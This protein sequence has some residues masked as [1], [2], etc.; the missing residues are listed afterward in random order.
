MTASSSSSSS[1]ETTQHDELP[2]NLMSTTVD[3]TPF[4][5][6]MNQAVK[7]KTAQMA[8]LRAEYDEYPTFYRN[9]IFPKD[10]AI[11]GARTASSFR[12]RLEEARRLKKLGNEEYGRG[13][14]GASYAKYE[15]AV[16][17]F[18]YLENKNPSWKTEGIK[19]SFIKKVFYTGRGDKEK[20]QVVNFL[21]ICYCNIANVCIKTKDYQTSI[22]ACGEA[23]SLD[24]KNAKAL[25]LRSRARTQP[26]SAGATEHG[27]AV[28]DLKLAMEYSP[29]DAT[30]RKELKHLR[31]T[32]RSGR[33]SDK[34]A[35]GGV[36]RKNNKK[37]EEEHSSD[38]ENIETVAGTRNSKRSRN[39]NEI[40]F[41]S[42]PERLRQTSSTTPVLKE[43]TN[44]DIGATTH[45]KQSSF[46]N[47]KR[48]PKT[49]KRMPKNGSKNSGTSI[50]TVNHNNGMRFD[51]LVSREKRGE[52]NNHNP[53]TTTT[54]PSH[55]PPTSFSSSL[56]SPIRKL[57][58][59]SPSKEMVADATANGIDLSDPRVI[60]LLEHLQKA[61]R[62][63]DVVSVLKDL[64]EDRNAE[65][66]RIVDGMTKKEVCGALKALKVKHSYFFSSYNR[67][68]LLVE[69]MVK[70]CDDGGGVNGED[71]RVVAAASGKS[72]P[73]LK[74]KF[75][76]TLLCLVVVLW[77]VRWGICHFQKKSRFE[78][79][80]V[81]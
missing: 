3:G 32:V 16:G 77:Y 38:K 76:G 41:G 25:Y 74:N 35:Y 69:T 64:E 79:A 61:H 27:L 6:I 22:H 17:V 4:S 42:L 37:E 57:N 13:C 55:P 51:D 19:D 49:K 75:L 48:R 43:V 21:V 8:P 30:I 50:P 20:Q 67:K 45:K 59:R 52:R 15:D 11:V 34:K 58:F 24:S 28:A 62:Q 60:K 44:D 47:K 63:G 12:K 66:R 72:P 33:D 36:F 7:L 68:K 29:R 70:G 81:S 10:D 53:E 54:A 9:S 26:K 2:S 71:V 18:K 31:E 1:D 56:P 39:E 5:V 46:R 78:Y 23:L 73:P 80:I 40:E 65:A 14:F